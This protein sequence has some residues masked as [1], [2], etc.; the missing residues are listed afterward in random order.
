MACG[1]RRLDVAQYRARAGRAGPRS[2][3]P[4]CSPPRGTCAVDSSRALS[5]GGL[6]FPNFAS[7]AP[8]GRMIEGHRHLFQ[9]PGCRPPAR[10][11][12]LQAGR[13]AAQ[14]GI[15]QPRLGAEAGVWLAR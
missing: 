3:A 2:Q 10:A 1:E 9:T 7:V 6:R 8:P 13:S 12:F 11:V 5:R 4:A 14:H 15:D